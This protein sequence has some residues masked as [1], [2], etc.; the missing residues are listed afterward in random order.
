[1]SSQQSSRSG[2][3]GLDQVWTSRSKAS[4]E[5]TLP[6]KRQKP[7]ADLDSQII[8]VYCPGPRNLL[9]IKLI[10]LI[11]GIS[12]KATSGSTRPTKGPN[13]WEETH[14]NTRRTCKVHSERSQ[15]LNPGPSQA[16]VLHWN[17]RTRSM[18]QQELKRSFECS[19]ETPVTAGVGQQVAAGTA[20]CQRCRWEDLF[21]V[22]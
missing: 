20:Y 13:T 18:I 11:I 9:E 4:R 19:G 16:V 21:S 3:A 2:P 12:C 14:W 5:G 8:A 7:G 17:Q 10:P 22:S 6:F 15:D 1:M